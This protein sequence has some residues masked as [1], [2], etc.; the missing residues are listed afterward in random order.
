MSTGVHTSGNN[1]WVYG[2][3]SV[4]DTSRYV[5]IK[6]ETLD[7]NYDL[8]YDTS[9]TPIYVDKQIIISFK[10]ENVDLNFVVNKEMQF[11]NLSNIIGTDIYNQIYPLI[12]GQ[13]QFTPKA[14]KIYSRLTSNDTA[15]ITRLGDTIEI[16]KFWSA[17]VITINVD[18]ATILDTVN[19]L[20]SIIN[21]VQPSFIYQNSFSPDDEEYFQQ[22]NLFTGVTSLDDINAEGAWDID[23]R[24]T[25]VKVGVYDTGIFW[26]HEDF[27]LTIGDEI[28]EDSKIVGGYDWQNHHQTWEDNND[29]DESDN[30]GTSVAGIIGAITDN[31]LGIAGIAG[32]DYVTA[33]YNTTGVQLFDLEVARDYWNPLST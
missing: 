13:G 7:Y 22:D 4:S 12:K 26:G 15:S 9:E 5:T 1:I 10:Y 16:P 24:G 28:F 14:F 25:H 18:P 27:H 19:N 31:N 30:H 21:Y 3:R 8:V 32:G 6:Y 23:K 20:D 33:D 2:R 17:F 29:I 11:E